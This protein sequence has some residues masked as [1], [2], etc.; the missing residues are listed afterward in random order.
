M[1]TTP[2]RSLPTHHLTDIIIEGKTKIVKQWPDDNSLAL[3]QAKDDITG[4]DGARHDVIQGKAELAT[5]T[6]CNVFRL[7][8]QAGIPLAFERQ[9][10][11]TSFLAHKCDMIPYEVVVRREA[12]GSFLKR[13][14]HLQKGAL[15][16]K[17]ITEFFLKTTG[18]TWQGATLPKDDPL[19]IFLDDTLHL[20]RPD[21][22]LYDQ[23]PCLVLHD[24]PLK[25]NPHVFTTMQTIAQKTFLVL[26]KAWQ[27]VGR[28]L[29]D[30]K[31]EFGFDTQGN[32]L[33]ADVIDNDSWRVV[34]KGLYLD[35]QVY[36]DGADLNT[37]SRLYERVRDLTGQFSIPQQQIVIWRGSP[38]DDVSA[39]EAACKPYISDS[40]HYVTVTTSMH[41]SPVAGYEELHHLVQQIPDT[42]VIAYIGRSNGAGPTLSANTTVPVITVPAG[43][44]T[45][46]DDVWSSLRAPSETPVM[47]VLEPSN[48][49]LAA[50]NILS[51]RNPALYSKVRQHQE[52]RLY[53]II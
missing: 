36:R 28:T 18:K 16:P 13:A 48:A 17:L 35:K 25:N 51:L 52:Q 33:L 43:W 45:F 14:R 26:E 11:S 8:K 29:V 44:Q 27:Q 49:I 3:L 50:L 34:E 53:N 12:H 1:N 15:F 41:K 38:K 9:V 24:Y 40:L 30:F 31:V 20:Y 47:T 19:A 2:S 42:V 37:V 4:G 32:I 46:P 7:L 10:D 6:T 39:F 22:P 23:E 21:M 5:Q